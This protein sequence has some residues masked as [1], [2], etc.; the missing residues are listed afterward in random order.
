MNTQDVKRQID[1]VL[2]DLADYVNLMAK[3]EE[4]LSAVSGG[5]LLLGL[6]ASNNVTARAATSIS[7][8]A[9]YS[10]NE[11]LNHAFNLRQLLTVYR[12][13]L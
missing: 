11:A 7:E 10:D 8:M 1:S 3:A 4:K 5:I 12:E 9:K 6:T 2:S 13:D